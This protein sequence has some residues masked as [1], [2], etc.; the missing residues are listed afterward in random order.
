MQSAGVAHYLHDHHSGGGGT[1][2]G[3]EIGGILS[4]CRELAGIHILCATF[5]PVIHHSEEN[6]GGVIILL[7]TEG[8]GAKW[9]KE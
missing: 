3:L 2:P 6:P 1:T 5:W 7:S 4:V 9:R 8:F